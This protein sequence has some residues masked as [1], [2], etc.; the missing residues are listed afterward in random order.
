MT[1]INL[2][3]QTRNKHCRKRA[4]TIVRI[5]FGI[6]GLSII[7]GWPSGNL[8]QRKVE[9]YIFRFYDFSRS[10]AYRIGFYVCISCYRFCASHVTLVNRMGFRYFSFVFTICICM[11]HANHH[12][13][14]QVRSNIGLDTFWLAFKTI[15]FYSCR[16]T[17]E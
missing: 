7:V 3:K 12:H 15:A 4:Q 9:L 16:F 8:A 1:A 13:H 5:E 11:F 2:K 14:H 10:F 6:V 17:G